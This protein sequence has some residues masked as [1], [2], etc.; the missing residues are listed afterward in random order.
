VVSGAD[1]IP[2]APNQETYPLSV[3]QA[4]AAASGREDSALPTAFR[5][6]G[7][8]DVGVLRETLTAIV[9]RHAPLRTVFDLASDPPMQRVLGEPR[10]DLPGVDLTR[11]ADREAALRETLQRLRAMRFDITK[12]PLFA[13][14][15]IVLSET[16]HVLFAAFSPMVFDGWSFDIFWSELRT[17]YAALCKGNPW[18]LVPL[19]VS[20]ADYVGWQRKVLDEKESQLS[21]FWTGRLGEQLPE[22]PLPTDR[23]RPNETSSRGRSLPF[24]LPPDVTTELRSFATRVGGTPQIVMLS[25]LYALLAR[26]GESRRVVVASPVEARRHTSFEAQIGPFVNMLLLPMDVDLSRS[27]REFVGRVRDDALSAYEHQELPIERL[28]VRSPRSTSS[29]PSPA[30]QVE[31]SFQQVSRRGS[32]MGPLTLTQIELE[33]GA[34]TND[35]TLWVKDWGDRVAG[36]VEFKTDL[37]DDETIR[38]WSACYVAYLAAL[39]NAP[40]ARMAEIDLLGDERT[41]VAR[42]AERVAA[43][44]PSWLAALPGAS[45][46]AGQPRDLR[47]Q[48]DVRSDEGLTQPLGVFGEL[49]VNGASTHVRARLRSDGTLERAPEAT[50][51]A[52]ERDYQPPQTDIEKKVVRLFEEAL[53]V[54]K[55][56]VDDDYFE[57]GG[58]SLLALK[59]FTVIHQTCGIKLPQAT[60]LT[61]RTPRALSKA[62][63]AAFSRNRDQCLVLLR[64]GTANQPLFFV[65][66]GDGETLLYLNLARR[67]K[68]TYDVY[69]LH[70]LARGV[71]PMVHT[72]VEEAARHYVSEMR[73][74]APRGPYR[75]GGLCAGGV[76]AFAIAAELESQ[77]E[78]VALLVIGEAAPGH[79]KKKLSS[80][81]ERLGRLSSLAR[82]GLS[83]NVSGALRAV[84]RSVLNA[85]R[86]ET[87]RLGL[88]LKNELSVR[89]L[90]ALAG[91]ERSWPSA[92]A[93]PSVRDVWALAEPRYK[94]KRLVRTA[95]VLVRAQTGDGSSDD[96]PLCELLVDPS[97]EW[98]PLS[99]RPMTFLDVE[100]GHSTMWQE[101]HV[102][103][104]AR[105]LDALLP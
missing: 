50:A 2:P 18:P 99:A 78:D 74:V 13:F 24:E 49:H 45:P 39:V 41:V 7:P 81:S 76:L 105:Q 96:R 33:S 8:L 25:A 66:D 55:V 93:A 92:L 62:I 97:F 85:G 6:K 26:F 67:L 95:P 1:A 86:Y 64:R 27:F 84:S 58:N 28:S 103:D 31:F 3:T 94:P 42:A 37:F 102:A 32:H 80:S 12:L 16:E 54:S 100:G 98:Q 34:A 46:P 9:R 15:L 38:H 91:S 72:S 65:H 30:F 20:Y 87:K 4:R 53:G 88:R 48:L 82:A 57:L 43:T 83:G 52:K 63:S 17:G 90:G 40:D 69:G 73:R 36:A 59:L 56:G 23:P 44:A 77:G 75:V 35:W 5:L 14:F 10:V 60:L 68:P 61:A 29:S 104:L 19:T 70:P 71:V 22:L 89:L 11:A 21:A 79:A 47:R 51:R 101:P